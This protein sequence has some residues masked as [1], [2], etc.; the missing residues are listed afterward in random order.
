MDS[1][2]WEIIQKLFHDA[3]DLPVAEQ[4]GLFCATHVGTTTR[5]WPMSRH[6]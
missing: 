1:A 6:C 4:Q 5:H 3:A 2:R